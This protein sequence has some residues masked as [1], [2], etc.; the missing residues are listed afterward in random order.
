MPSVRAC[1]PAVVLI[2]FN[3]SASPVVA[4]GAKRGCAVRA[5]GGWM[6]LSLWGCCFWEPKGIQCHLRGSSFDPLARLQTLP[7]ERGPCTHDLSRC[8]KRKVLISTA[9]ALFISSKRLVAN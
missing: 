1:R 9:D 5:G 4:L 7:H 3:P 6:Q 2:T 8:K